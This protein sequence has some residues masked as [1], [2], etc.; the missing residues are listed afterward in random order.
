MT[1]EGLDTVTQYLVDLLK[2]KKG[3]IV[4]MVSLKTVV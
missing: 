1:G 2:K 3:Q 4:R